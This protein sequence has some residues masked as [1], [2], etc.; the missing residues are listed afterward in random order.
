MPPQ[1]SSISRRTRAS[2]RHAS[3]RRAESDEQHTQRIEMERHRISRSRLNLTPEDREALN[4]ADRLR[5][6]RNRAVQHR[7]DVSH[8]TFT[9]TLH[10]AAFEYNNTTDYSLHRSVNIG[11]MNKVCQHCKAFK[12]NNETPGMCCANGKVKLPALNSPPNHCGHWF[13]EQPHNQSIS[14]RIFR[15]TIRVFKWLRLVQ[16][17]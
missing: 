11:T 7:S 8:A 12:F 13:P 9:G 2:N 16:R 1:R 10:R 6:R 15:T 5:M 3:R 4:T 17:I 14:W